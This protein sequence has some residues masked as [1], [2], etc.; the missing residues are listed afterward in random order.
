MP[1]PVTK[2]LAS[3]LVFFSVVYGQLC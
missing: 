3:V 1:R 2:V